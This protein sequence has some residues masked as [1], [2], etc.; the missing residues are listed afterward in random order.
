MNE[1]NCNLQFSSWRRSWERTVLVASQA[2]NVGLAVF[3]CCW[4]AAKLLPS[5]LSIFVGLSSCC[6]LAIWLQ[7]FTAFVWPAFCLSLFHYLNAILDASCPSPRPRPRPRLC[8]K[9]LYFLPLPRPC[10]CHMSNY[11]SASR[12]FNMPGPVSPSLFL[13]YSELDRSNPPHWSH[14]I[15]G[16]PLKTPAVLITP[17]GGGSGQ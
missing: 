13:V 12:T 7:Q 6:S 3:T 2:S 9:T 11:L 5:F 15:S 16:R 8:C 4:F 1:C 17:R 10:I 14:P